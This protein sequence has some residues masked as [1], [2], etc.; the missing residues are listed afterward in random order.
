MKWRWKDKLPEIVLSAGVARA[1]KG[2][3]SGGEYLWLGE[4]GDCDS[5]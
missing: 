2:G 3:A 4:E 5:T 1:S